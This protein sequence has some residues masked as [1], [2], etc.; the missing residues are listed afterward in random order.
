MKNSRYFENTLRSNQETKLQN[1]TKFILPF[2]EINN[3]RGRLGWSMAL[4]YY[5]PDS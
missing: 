5:K 3:S 2:K 1:L 4:D